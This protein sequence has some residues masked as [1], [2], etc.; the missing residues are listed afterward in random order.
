MDVIY[1]PLL[2]QILYTNMPSCEPVSC[3]FIAPD[4]KHLPDKN[5]LQALFNEETLQKIQRAC[6]LAGKPAGS[7]GNP[8]PVVC[9]CFSIG[10][11]K[12]IQTILEKNLTSVEAIGECLQAGTNCG[13][14]LPEL[15][16]LLAKYSAADAA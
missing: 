6:L 14:C 2:V 13:S 5:W 1:K 12:I 15:R 9:S 8:G 4:H 10:K 3:L 16:Q 11:N 7:E